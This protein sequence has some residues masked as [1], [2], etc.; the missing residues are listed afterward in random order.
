[1]ETGKKVFTLALNLTTP[2]FFLPAYGLDNSIDYFVGSLRIQFNSRY[3][4]PPTFNVPN[5]LREMADE[6]TVMDRHQYGAFKFIQRL[7]KFLA[8]EYIQMIDGFIQDQ[9]IAVVQHQDGQHQPRLLAQ[10]QLTGG[11][12][13]FI[14]AD[15]EVGQ[16]MPGFRL[17]GKSKADIF[18]SGFFS[19]KCGKI[20]RHETDAHALA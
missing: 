15:L 12:K 3:H 7:F 11:L 20:L 4:D 9:Q 17:A 10:A 5:F 6:I 16:K 19:L 14:A 2:D 8:A 18:H 1:M 13:G